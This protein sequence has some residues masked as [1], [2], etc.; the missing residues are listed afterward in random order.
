MRHFR[1]PASQQE[2]SPVVV[3]DDE[4]SNLCKPVSSTLGQVNSPLGS[5]DPCALWI[6]LFSH[7]RIELDSLAA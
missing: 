6:K 5:T 7:E 2:S 4:Y 3:F 1:P